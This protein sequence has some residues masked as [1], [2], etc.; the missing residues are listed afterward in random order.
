[1]SDIT[2]EQ[3]AANWT[4]Q[5]CLLRDAYAASKHVFTH[6]VVKQAHTCPDPAIIEKGF[7][8]KSFL[9]DQAAVRTTDDPVVASARRDSRIAQANAIGR[10]IEAELGFV[11]QL[12]TK[13]KHMIIEYEMYTITDSPLVF[14]NGL[15]LVHHGRDSYFRA[16]RTPDLYRLNDQN[17]LMLVATYTRPI[18]ADGC[19]R[20]QITRPVNRP[21]AHGLPLLGPDPTPTSTPTP[22]VPIAYTV[23]RQYGYLNDFKK[24][25]TIAQRATVNKHTY[26]SV[27]HGIDASY[28]GA[29]FQFNTT[30]HAHFFRAEKKANHMYVWMGTAKKVDWKPAHIPTI[31]TMIA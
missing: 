10:K 27:F 29:V 1:M 14:N 16:S 25:M 21:T 26:T 28:D 17:E 19:R 31:L 6:P 20:L 12:V 8:I 11:R 23:L 24:P 7:L 2:L 13:Y 5:I 18:D 22:T 9:N 3:Y 15:K 30:T 4:A